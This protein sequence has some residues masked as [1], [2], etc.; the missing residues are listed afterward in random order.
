MMSSLGIMDCTAIRKF[1]EKST[2]TIEE[3]IVFIE[4]NRSSSKHLKSWI[5]GQHMGQRDLSMYSA[6]GKDIL[7]MVGN[8]TYG[9]YNTLYGDSSDETDPDCIYLTNTLKEYYGRPRD[10]RWNKLVQGATTVVQ[11][12]WEFGKWGA[13]KAIDAVKY[14]L[15]WAITKG[16]E[17]W[18]WISSNPKT[19]YFA[20]TAIAQ[21]KTR[22]CRYV[23]GKLAE[24]GIYMG[25][26]ESVLAFIKKMYPDKEPPPPSSTLGDLYKGMKGVGE[27]VTLEVVQKQS[28]PL[29]KGIFSMGGTLLKAGLSG[30]VA[31]IPFAG[32]MLA[33]AVTAITDAVV[34]Q[35]ADQVAQ[36]AEMACYMKSV[37]NTF[38][39]LIEVINPFSCLEELAKSANMVLKDTPHLSVEA[40]NAATA[41]VNTQP[42]PEAAPPGAPAQLD[43]KPLVPP[44]T[45]W[46][47][48]QTKRRRSSRRR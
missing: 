14:G 32:P 1:L 8:N 9:M 37:E 26:K 12:A 17:L 44:R 23:G 31:G 4:N 30:A 21:I 28:G 3:R 29:I 22:V 27:Q 35:T 47:G 33:G 41:V 40:K 45:G 5:Q 48:G 7:T 18:T 39:K 11:N 6:V 34:E 15:S 42:A 20:L 46:W 2:M 16:F 43:G 19:A 38:S 25:Q 13:G 36:A 24:M 10:N